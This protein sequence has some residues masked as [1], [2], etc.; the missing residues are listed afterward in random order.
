MLIRAA[1]RTSGTTGH[2]R[3]GN[4][5][6]RILANTREAGG[7]MTVSGGFNHSIWSGMARPNSG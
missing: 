3:V 6:C 1:C 2:H 5:S 7:V 4:E